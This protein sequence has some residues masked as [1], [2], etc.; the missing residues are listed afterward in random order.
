MMYERREKGG[1]HKS[2]KEAKNSPKKEK[3]KAEWEH[4]P[5]S[6]WGLALWVW[7]L[8]EVNMDELHAVRERKKEK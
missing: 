5:H 2:T 8:F 1:P 6:E 3:E 4:G 7:V